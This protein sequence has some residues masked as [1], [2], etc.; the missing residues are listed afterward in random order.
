MRLLDREVTSRPDALE[1]TQSVAGD[2]VD[3]QPLQSGSD[4]PLIGREPHLAQLYATLDRVQ[5]SGTPQCIFVSGRSGEG[6]TSLVEHFLQ[7]LRQDRRFSVLAGRCHDRESVP[8]KAVTLLETV[9]VSGKSLPLAE[10]F[11]A[12][13]QDCRTTG[14]PLRACPIT[15][16]RCRTLDETQSPRRRP[17]A[18]RSQERPDRIRRDDRSERGDVGAEGEP[19]YMASMNVIPVRIGQR[20]ESS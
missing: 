1:I 17:A 4:G 9:A 3:I 19:Q 14:R 11:Q 12:A 5:Q 15:T 10:T 18:S 7:P 16:R 13:L 6:K 20:C 2:V 8:F